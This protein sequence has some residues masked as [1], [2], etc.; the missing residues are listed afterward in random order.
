[1][2]GGPLGA[3]R[4]L[5]RRFASS[6]LLVPCSLFYLSSS[7]PC[8]Y[9]EI[10]LWMLPATSQ[11]RQAH[12]GCLLMLLAVVSGGGECAEGRGVGVGVGCGARAARQAAR[13]KPKGRGAP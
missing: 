12:S 9:M 5:L 11:T 2:V 1:V 13:A 7:L 4:A 10:W 6:F 8:A 3:S